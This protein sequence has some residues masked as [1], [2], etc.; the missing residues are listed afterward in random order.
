MELKRSNQRWTPLDK[1]PLRL[2]LPAYTLL[3]AERVAEKISEVR[4]K[5][6]TFSLKE[7]STF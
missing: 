1:T 5:P 6:T 2:E 4:G 7:I 3:L